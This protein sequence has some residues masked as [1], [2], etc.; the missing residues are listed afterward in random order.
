[1]YRDPPMIVKLNKNRICAP[2]VL[3]SLIHM[4]KIENMNQVCDDF[5]SVSTQNNVRLENDI[6]A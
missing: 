3:Y 4:V 1:M 6:E 5:M 2:L